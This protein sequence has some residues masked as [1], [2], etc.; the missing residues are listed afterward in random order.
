MASPLTVFLIPAGCLARSPDDGDAGLVGRREHV[1]AV[2]DQRR[3]AS[4]DSAVAPARRIAWIVAMPTT[5][6]SKR[7]S[8][9]GLAT[10]TMRTPG[11]ARCAGARDD[12]VGAFHRLDGDDRLV[13]DGDRLADV[14]RRDGVG[15]R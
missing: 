6:T 3:P 1:L 7:M 10:L 5:G 9:F 11:P 13:L 4:I 15:H 2:H 12:L 14:E 8:W